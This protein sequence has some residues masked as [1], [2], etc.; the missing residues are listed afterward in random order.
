MDI[1]ATNGHD[2][3]CAQD[4]EAVRAIKKKWKEA[5]KLAA[6]EL[7]RGTKMTQVGKDMAA[8]G[9]DVEVMRAMAKRCKEAFKLA[10]ERSLNA[11]KMVREE[12][13]KASKADEALRLDAG[14]SPRETELASSKPRR[15]IAPTTVEEEKEEELCSEEEDRM[16]HHIQT[17]GKTEWNAMMARLQERMEEVILELEEDI[18][19][20]SGTEEGPWSTH[21]TTRLMKKKKKKTREPRTRRYSA[22][23]ALEMG[24]T[25]RSAPTLAIRLW[26]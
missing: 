6:E 25:L 7:L 23:M 12:M 18:S 17:A 13:E 20:K 14:K 19:D 5:G 16:R 4:A 2:A 10:L 11:A 15:M 26:C 22:G 8:V 3:T 9:Q 21:P 1:K 24:R